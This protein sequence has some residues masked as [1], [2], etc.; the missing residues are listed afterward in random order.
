MMGQLALLEC[1]LEHLKPCLVVAFSAFF[2]GHVV[3]CKLKID[4]EH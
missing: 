4:G 3:A 1:R 2:L